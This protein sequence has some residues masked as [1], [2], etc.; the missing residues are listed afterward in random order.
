MKIATWN[1]NSL[2]VRQA[3]VEDWLVDQR[4]D[5]LV[6][7]EIKMTDDLFPEEA[8]AEF[9]YQ[10]R[11][12]GQKTYNGVATLVQEGA[13]IGDDVITD[14]PGLDDP[15]RR[16]LATTIDGVRVINLYVPNG[17]AVGSE[18]YD[19]KLRWLKQLTA[20][21]EKERSHYEDIVILGDFN[22]APD[23]KDVWDPKRWAGKILC[24]DAERQALNELLSLGFVDSYRL[25]EQP[26]SQFSW[27]DYRG[28]GYQRNHGLRIDLILCS[29]SLRAKVQKSWIDTEPRSWEQPSDHAPAIIEL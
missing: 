9:G 11:W 10:A 3:Q 12:S 29:E 21:V 19:Y 4:P 14:I 27:W 18:K 24:S 15:Q 6:L 22:I 7:Q 20:W 2:R 28:G 16:V 1:V 26:E 17:S 13:M 25:F 5:V 8:M 23:D